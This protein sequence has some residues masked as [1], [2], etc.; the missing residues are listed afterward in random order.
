MSEVFNICLIH[1]LNLPQTSSFP[2]NQLS[3]VIFLWDISVQPQLLSASVWSYTDRR[4]PM[5]SVSVLLLRTVILHLCPSSQDVDS[6]QHP[7]PDCP[8]AFPLVWLVS[9]IH[10]LTLITWFLGNRPWSSPVHHSLLPPLSLADIVN[11]T[12]HCFQLL[13]QCPFP[14]FF[15]LL[16]C[17]LMDFSLKIT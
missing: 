10:F 15:P 3:L 17:H 12:Q 6:A 4:Q 2:W 5:W 14:I 1:P 16:L 13:L 9:S 8:N 7:H 11:V